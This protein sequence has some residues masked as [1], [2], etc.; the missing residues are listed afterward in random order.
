MR[1]LIALYLRKSYRLAVR[2]RAFSARRTLPTYYA[3]LYVLLLAFLDHQAITSWR[4]QYRSLQLL[5]K[6]SF[7]LR[8]KSGSSA[9]RC[10]CGV[11]SRRKVA[12]TT[13][14]LLAMASLSL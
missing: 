14:T 5:Y 9:L 1:R 6:A 4:V 13:T 11:T 2:I 8:L 12:L 7:S 3:N 10:A